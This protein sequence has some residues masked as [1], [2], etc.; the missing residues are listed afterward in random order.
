MLLDKAPKLSE[1]GKIIIDGDVIAYRAAYS[2]E[3]SNEID[4]QLKVDQVMR[5]ILN[6]T[7]TTSEFDDYSLYLT[8]SNN[9]RHEI[10]V[11]YPYKGNRSDKPKPKYLPH[12]RWYL[13]DNYGAVIIE[14]Q[15]ADDAIAIEATVEG[16]SSIVVSIDKDML[17]IP[18]FHYNQNKDQ[19][20]SV[21]EFEG[22]EFFYEQIL[23]GDTADNIVGL[24]GIGPVK[25]KKILKGAESEQDLWT[26][27][28][29]AYD[30]DEQRV[31][32]NAR[33]L[34]LRR[35]QEELWVPPQLPVD[36]EEPSQQDTDQG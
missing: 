17:Q 31:I 26:A 28:L 15:E 21:S 27:V 12:A 8:G 3:D 2:S 9:F 6:K 5:F 14:G 11:T 29:E 34:W 36:D 35:Q 32:E 13:K 19:W 4:T 30:G 1:R 18:C 25:A 24:K 20:W 33:L 7:R 16:P 10:A 23:T 22:L